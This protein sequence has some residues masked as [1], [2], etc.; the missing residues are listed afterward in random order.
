MLWCKIHGGQWNVS[1][2]PCPVNSELTEYPLVLTSSEMVAPI[3]LNG[4]PGPHAIIPARR[5]SRVAE[6]REQPSG[7]LEDEG[8]M[9]TILQVKAHP[10]IPLPRLRMYLRCHRDNHL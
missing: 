9:R 6:M 4:L 7:S 5:A 10:D 1:P 3:F 8:W 2:I